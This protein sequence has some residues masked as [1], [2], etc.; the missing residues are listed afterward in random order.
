MATISAW[1]VGSFHK[2]TEFVP[3]LM[4]SVPRTT[5]AA[6]GPPFRSFMLV[7]ES[8]MTRDIK[9]S[10]PRGGG[11]KVSLIRFLTANVKID[12]TCVP[13]HRRRLIRFVVNKLGA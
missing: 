1:A 12:F 13:N 5:R 6:N 11:F 3:S 9:A 8:S 7:R 10:L 2:V 4:T